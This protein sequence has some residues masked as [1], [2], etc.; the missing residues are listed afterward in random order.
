MSA[1]Q[2]GSIIQTVELSR[3]YVWT[4]QLTRMFHQAARSSR[5]PGSGDA[6]P[7]HLAE[8]SGALHLPRPSSMFLGRL[9][10]ILQPLAAQLSKTSGLKDQFLL[11]AAMG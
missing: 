11:E 8:S 10:G 1:R 2:T 3:K 6:W 9:V 7:K 5:E 4:S